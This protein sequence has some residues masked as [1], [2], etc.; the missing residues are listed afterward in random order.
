METSRNE[1]SQRGVLG[2]M[3][4]RGVSDTSKA[5]QI[6]ETEEG[7][8]GGKCCA[9]K[10]PDGSWPDFKIQYARLVRTQRTCDGKIR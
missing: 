5:K 3:G 7:R 8:D 4:E 10:G 2:Q 9:E 6:D 1:E